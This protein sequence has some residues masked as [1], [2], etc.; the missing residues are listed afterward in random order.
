FIRDSLAGVA[1]WNRIIDK[2]GLPFRLQAPH[3]AFNR[4]IGTLAAV[5]VSP[6]GRVVSDDEWTAHEREWLA[7]PPDRSVLASLM[8]RVLEPGKFAHWIAPP[9]VGVNRQPADFRYVRFG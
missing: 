6:D 9:V 1:R 3:K 2:A 5:K 7:T 8:G 4:R